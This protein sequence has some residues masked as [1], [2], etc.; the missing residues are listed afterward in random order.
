MLA[1]LI[2]HDGP[3]DYNIEILGIN[4]WQD[5]PD[6]NEAMS[7]QVDLPWLQDTAAADAKG[8]LSAEYRDVIILDPANEQP[9]AAFNLSVNDLRVDTTRNRLEII[10]RN[11]ATLK[12]EDE[13]KLSDFWEDEAFGSTDTSKPL[14][15]GDGDR[16]IDLLEYAH[17]SDPTTPRSVPD[18]EYGEEEIDGQRY[19]TV[20]FRRR[21]GLAGGLDYVVEFSWR[22]Q[23]WMSG[24]TEVEEYSVV[25]PYDGT[26][27]EIVTYR[28]RT[29]MDE[30]KRQGFLRVRCVLPD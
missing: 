29:A 8:A 15:N 5:N 3:S 26:G 23:D 16:A 20:T 7:S 6:N 9:V 22:L 10:L 28:A 21:L 4:W 19:L 12:D 25:N 27:T 18:L 13:D 11:V 24:L 14:S 2:A 1:D 17:A 30:A